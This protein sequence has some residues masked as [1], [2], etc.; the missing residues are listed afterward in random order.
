MSRRAPACYRRRV[1]IRVLLAHMPGL[2]HDVLAHSLAAEPDLELVGEE[3]GAAS[4]ARAAG[5]APV[6]PDAPGAELA[7]TRPDVLV[8]GLYRDEPPG[9]CAD[10]LR[11]FPR[12]KV[13][14]LEGMG[15]RA[16]MHELRP[17]YAPLGALSAGEIAAAI[18]CAARG[19]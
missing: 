9:V 4:P 6:A 16:S 7:R 10:V 19:R 12:L 17:T 13:I 18:R 2:L 8:L 3:A 5:D 15:M 1:S 14:A 11:E